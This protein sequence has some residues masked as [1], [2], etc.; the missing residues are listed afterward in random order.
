[1]SANTLTETLPSQ[2]TA[3][4]DSMSDL[5]TVIGQ[6]GITPVA[7]DPGS[8]RASVTVATLDGGMKFLKMLLAVTDEEITGK[9]ER[10]LNIANVPMLTIGTDQYDPQW[11]TRK[12]ETHQWAWTAVAQPSRQQ[13]KYMDDT[14]D[15]VTFSFPQE[16]VTTLVQQFAA[17]PQTL[18]FTDKQN[19]WL[20]RHDKR[21][22]QYRDSERELF[23]A[24][25]YY[26]TTEDGSP[27]MEVPYEL[28]K[29]CHADRFYQE[30]VQ[31]VAITD[32]HSLDGDRTSAVSLSV[33]SAV[34]LSAQT[35]TRP[36]DMAMLLAPRRR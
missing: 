24:Q 28:R 5:L 17:L 36:S 8:E 9:V 27:V 11:D 3:S 26:L 7:S 29:Q 35:E 22:R 34:S 6:H 21:F 20:D 25:P 32:V 4:D 19:K 14:Y 23:T 13:D 30:P 15:Q 12:D 2:A 1:M 10:L 16:F 31:Q 33:D 18:T